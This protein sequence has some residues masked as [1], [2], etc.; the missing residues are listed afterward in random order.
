MSLPCKHSVAKHVEMQICHPKLV[1]VPE[2]LW[3]TLC[4]EGLYPLKIHAL[5][6]KEVRAGCSCTV[7]LV[8]CVVRSRGTAAWLPAGSRSVH[9][10]PEPLP[11]VC[12]FCRRQPW[13]FRGCFY[14]Q[15]KCKQV[16]ICNNQAPK[17]RRAGSACPILF[18]LEQGTPLLIL[19]QTQRGG[20]AGRSRLLL[21]G[22]CL[23]TSRRPGFQ[24]LE[25]FFL[26][27]QLCRLSSASARE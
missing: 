17:E 3:L 8:G 15:I 6:Y 24:K 19:L 9:R 14:N 2:S 1:L 4:L 21:D 16:L 25:F 12:P 23:I 20:G 13:W 18:Q 27:P 10:G 5:F 22:L 7:P 26:S 11:M